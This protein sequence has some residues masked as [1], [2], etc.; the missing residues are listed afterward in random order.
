MDD[1]NT[2]DS[3]PINEKLNCLVTKDKMTGIISFSA[4]SNGGTNLTLEQIKEALA[5][6]NIKYGI[7]EELLEQLSKNHEYDFKYIIANGT[8]PIH[9]EDGKIEICV[10]LP[11]GDGSV[12]ITE[13]KDGSV[14]FKKLGLITNVT[15]GT[16]LATKTLPTEGVDGVNVCMGVLKAKKGKDVRFY[17]G[18]NIVVSEDGLSAYAATDGQPVYQNDI[19]DVLHVLTIHG[20]VDAS[21][22]NVEF[23]GDVTVEGN[24][25]AGYSINAGGSIEVKGSVEGSTLIAKGNIVL[26]HGVQGGNIGKLVA[27]KSVIAK[28]IENCV[29]EAGQDIVSESIIQSNVT[30]GNIIQVNAGKGNIIGGEILATS[31]IFVNSIGGAMETPTVLKIGVPVDIVQK[32]QEVLQEM[33]L[34]SKQLSEINKNITFLFEKNKSAALSDAKLELLNRLNTTKTTLETEVKALRKEAIRLSSLIESSS[35][36]SIVVDK[37]IFPGVRFYVGNAYKRIHDKRGRSKVYGQ[38]SEVIVESI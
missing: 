19:L 8:Y 24:V 20:N 25:N 35:K 34:K 28:F 26:R 6:N 32:N 31:S 38:Y 14:D 33:Q 3:N 1:F 2:S 17:K 15:K 27:G 29:V 22:G 10:Q 5:S 23:L 36:G 18:K 30:A 7:N 16:L 21:V 37:A 13:N 9:G 4:P 11:L 12:N